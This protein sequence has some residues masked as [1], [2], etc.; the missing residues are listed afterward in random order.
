MPVEIQLEIFLNHLG[1]Y[2]NSVV[3]LNLADWAGV[4]IGA[5]ELCTKRCMVAILSLHDNLIKAP[6]SQEKSEAQAWVSSQ[7]CASWRN[8]YISIDGTNFNLFQKPSHYGET[9]FDRKSNYSL[10]AQ[11]W[12][13]LFVFTYLQLLYRLPYCHIISKPLTTLLDTLVVFTT[14]LHFRILSSIANPTSF[15]LQMSGSGQILL[16]HHYPLV[17]HHLKNLPVALFP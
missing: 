3:P 16:T 15:C 12:L 11:V 17:S 10:N 2:G 5:V 7:V 6:T 1:H 9:F 13:K 8:G 14:Q 4:L